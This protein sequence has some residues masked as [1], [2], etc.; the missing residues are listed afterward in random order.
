MLCAYPNAVQRGFLNAA[1]KQ[2]FCGV[3]L[4]SEKEMSSK[5]AGGK[6]TPS[7]RENKPDR[8]EY[9]A[10][11]EGEKPVQSKNVVDNKAKTA[12]PRSTEPSPKTAR[13]T[14]QKRAS[15]APRKKKAVSSEP[16]DELD[17]AFPRKKQPKR[18]PRK[19]QAKTARTHMTSCWMPLPTKRPAE[20]N[21][22]GVPA[23]A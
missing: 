18:A 16:Y 2:K 13:S 5:K 12:K 6:K 9:D 8:D 4:M 1:G 14:S 20:K 19:R 11:L 15:A 7:R 3:Y 10:L 21:P 17:D 23:R 22:A